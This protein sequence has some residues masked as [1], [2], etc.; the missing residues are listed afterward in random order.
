MAFIFK[1][2]NPKVYPNELD[3]LVSWFD[4][5]DLSTITTDSGRVIAWY[6]KKTGDPLIQNN[7]LKQPTLEEYRGIKFTPNTGQILVSATI[8]NTRTNLVYFYVMEIK[9]TDGWNTTQTVNL[10]AIFIANMFGRVMSFRGDANQV[11]SAETQYRR[12]VLLGNDP[13]AYSGQIKTAKGTGARMIPNNRIFMSVNSNYGVDSNE[14]SHII[15]AINITRVAH[16]G[17][18]PTPSGKISLGFPSSYIPNTTNNPIEYV[19]FH[20]IVAI[21]ENQ[22]AVT[23]GT[24][25]NSNAELVRQYLLNKWNI[26]PLDYN[27][28]L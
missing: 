7:T 23:Y 24:L 16:K 20:Q 14:Y 25:S 17:G 9:I 3:S 21:A 22:G 18:T 11:Y 13:Y 2:K 26:I 10:S 12:P 19:I 28:L 27:T 5:K 4:A 8:D 15:H 1:S 6:D